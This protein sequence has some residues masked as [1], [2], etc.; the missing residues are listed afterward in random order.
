MNEIVAIIKA[1]WRSVRSNPLFVAFSSAA[2]GAIVSTLQ[3]EL[4]SGRI[5]WTRAGINKLT[6]YAITAGIF[7][8]VHLYRTPPG[9]NPNK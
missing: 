7:A 6:G 4:A 1:I 8:V 2:T 5:D 3:D 9:S